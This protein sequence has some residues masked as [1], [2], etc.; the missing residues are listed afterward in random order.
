[1]YPEEKRDG[2]GTGKG[3]LKKLTTCFRSC[4]LNWIYNLWQEIE[5]VV[6]E[7]LT[8]QTSSNNKPNDVIGVHTSCETKYRESISISFFLF[9]IFRSRSRYK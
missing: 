2:K 1:M 5:I 8:C 3:R 9:L 6:A 4:L 7:Y